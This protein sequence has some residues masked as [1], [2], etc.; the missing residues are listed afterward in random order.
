MYR[1]GYGFQAIKTTYLHCN[2]CGEADKGY[3]SID[4]DNGMGGT[5]RSGYRRTEMRGHTTS[6]SCEKCNGK[7]LEI[8]SKCNGFGTTKCKG[9][10]NH[11][12]NPSGYKG[13]SFYCTPCSGSGYRFRECNKCSGTKAMLK[14]LQKILFARIVMA[15]GGKTKYQEMS[16]VSI[17]I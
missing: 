13:F 1:Y 4:G 5:K 12:V 8:C 14:K 17:T 15:K 16:K 11:P 9:C 6:S 3:Y 10:S 7:G 2:D